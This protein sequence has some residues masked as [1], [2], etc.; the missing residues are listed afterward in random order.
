MTAFYVAHTSVLFSRLFISVKR[1]NLAIL[2][3]NF[4][5][6]RNILRNI[7]WDPDTLKFLTKISLIKETVVHQKRQH[8]LL[9]ALDLAKKLYLLR[10]DYLF[11]FVFSCFRYS[12]WTSLCQRWGWSW[13]SQWSN[14]LFHCLN[15][16]QIRH[17]PQNWMAFD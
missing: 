1:I 15:T 5:I 8:N 17:W 6:C 4:N 3:A 2:L 11:V 7:F 16:Q 10:S 13:G 12:S 9:E 14:H